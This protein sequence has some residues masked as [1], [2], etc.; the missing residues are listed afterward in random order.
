MPFGEQADEPVALHKGDENNRLH[1]LVDGA[2][3]PV[4][5]PS[6]SLSTRATWLLPHS[7]TIP[8]DPD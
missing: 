3:A 4:E 2:D 6:E 1:G 5:S 8:H 7:L